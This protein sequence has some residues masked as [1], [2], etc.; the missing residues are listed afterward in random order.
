MIVL[1]AGRHGFRSLRRGA[2]YRN[3]ATSMTAIKPLLIVVTGRP[4]SGKTTLSRLL[5]KEMRCPLLSRDEFKEGY[6]NTFRSS[7][8][9]LPSEAAMDIYETYFQTAGLLLSSNISIVLEA[10]FQHK[11]WQ[12]G[13]VPLMNLADIRMVICEIAPELAKQRFIHRMHEDADREKYH[14]DQDELAR[15]ADESLV[16]SYHAP[17]MPVPTLRVDTTGNYRPGLEEIVKFLSSI[18]PF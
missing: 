12:P 3:F 10:A 13:L 14:G 2:K 9:E 11:L 16:I 8:A 7:Q 17:D 6:V 15:T 5:S 4:A 1:R 18:Q